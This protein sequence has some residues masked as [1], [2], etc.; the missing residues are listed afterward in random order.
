M[1]TEK[2]FYIASTWQTVGNCQSKSPSSV[3]KVSIIKKK[4][5]KKKTN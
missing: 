1:T 5:K 2:A 3:T 4:E